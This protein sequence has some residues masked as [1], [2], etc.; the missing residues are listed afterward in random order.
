LS[1]AYHQIKLN[2]IPLV[3][4]GGIWLFSLHDFF[5]WDTVQLGSK[6]AHYFFEQDK[7][8]LLLPDQIDSGHF[9]FFGM[10][11]SLWW[12]VF[13]KSLWI[14]HLAML[15][16]ILCIAYAAGKLSR[17]LFERPYQSLVVILICIE[18][19]LL[20]QVSLISPDVVLIAALLLSLVFFV[21]EKRWYLSISL[22]LMALI[23]LR[24]FML[25]MAFLA[26]VIIIRKLHKNRHEWLKW[27]NIFLPALLSNVLFF[28]YH[29][30]QKNWVGFHEASPWAP[31]F[32][33]VSTLE[34][35][36]NFCLL[37]WRWLDFGRIWVFIA[38]A[39]LMYKSK[40]HRNP[41]ILFVQVLLMAT[42]C[43]FLLVTVGF[44]SL[45][46]H[47][48]Y[49]PGYLLVL[50]IF[51]HFLFRSKFTESVKKQIYVLVLMGLLS[52]H[53]WI[54]PDKIAQGWD[55]SLAYKPVMTLYP[56]LYDY[57]REKSI[58]PSEVSAFFPFLSEEKFL[59]LNDRDETFNDFSSSRTKYILM[60]NL[61]N[62]I[63]DS[64]FIKYAAEN[65]LF[66]KEQSGVWI[67][68]FLK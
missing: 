10:Y 53:L 41:S 38:I 24:G 8:S 36:K 62:D 45:T 56:K 47:R 11:L 44:Q 26:A 46:A 15:P 19:S 42:A 22:L 2:L 55:S 20:A 25:V 37:I 29:Y 12:K 59:F 57:L 14:S 39:W 5:F 66:Y 34:I 49:L 16:W 18:P 67:G 7:F 52:G 13:G 4:L 35:L 40:I 54:Y 68:L 31:S 32:A 1:P 6:Q 43:I 58:P 21:A 50:L 61:N 65:A 48:Y 17:L 9:P 60:S 64:L 23:S 27:I 28:L 30:Y 3:I 33:G 51:C 63:P